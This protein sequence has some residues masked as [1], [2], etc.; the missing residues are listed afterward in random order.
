M[1]WKTALGTAAA[2]LF[3]SLAGAGAVQA[4]D[5]CFDRIH[6]EEHK[7]QRDVRRHG[8]DSRQAHNRRVKIDRLR[9]QCGRSRWRGDDRW[10]DRWENGRSRGRCD[11]GWNRRHGWRRW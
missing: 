4:H 2:G 1:R 6:K 5:S 10:D 8:W 3:F 9:W 11:Y 7:L